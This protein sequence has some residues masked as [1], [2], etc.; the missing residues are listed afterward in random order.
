MFPGRVCTDQKSS[1]IFGRSQDLHTALTALSNRP[2]TSSAATPNDRNGS[3]PNKAGND[4]YASVVLDLT[5]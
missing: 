4:R 2:T 5:Q 1:V 3:D